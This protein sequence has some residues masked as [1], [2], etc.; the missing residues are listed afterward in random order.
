MRSCWVYIFWGDIYGRES[1]RQKESLFE[2][3]NEAL[4]ILISGEPKKSKINEFKNDNGELIEAFDDFIVEFCLVSGLADANEFVADGTFLD[5]Y[6]ND[7]KALYPDE[8]KYIQEF[9]TKNKK[10]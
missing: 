9:L 2:D 3:N 10:H 7:F 1:C 5:G 6:C 8:I 4:Q